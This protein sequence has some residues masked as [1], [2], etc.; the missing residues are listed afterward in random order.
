MLRSLISQAKR[1]Y[2]RLSY[3]FVNSL[4]LAA[5]IIL[6]I[7]RPMDPSTSSGLGV[8]LIAAAIV[9]FLYFFH[10]SVESSL[11][12]VKVFYKEWG[13]LG[14]REDRSDAEYYRQ[15]LQSAK[16]RIDIMA[17]SLARLQTDL[18][19]T[20]KEVGRRK[21]KIRLLV[22]N[23]SS[24]FVNARVKDE[25]IPEAFNLGERIKTTAESIKAR[26]IPNLQIRYYDCMPYVNYFRCD[27]TLLVGPYLAGKPSR[28]TITLLCDAD[29]RFA[30]QFREH[31]ERVWK[32]H[33]LS[34]PA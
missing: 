11:D 24:A 33:E 28:T 9:G 31:Y 15:L 3:V 4:V 10:Y 16:E 5:G 32:E 13:I 20:L 23:P 22:L 17:I 19:D 26:R 29:S 30:A 34:A 6:V 8:S 1:Q 2:Q 25:G 27:S 21:V 12:D 7:S 18:G 14:A